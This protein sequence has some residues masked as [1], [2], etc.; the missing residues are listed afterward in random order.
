MVYLP[1]ENQNIIMKKLSLITILLISCFA[2]TNAQQ[3][4]NSLLWK[5]TG[6]SIEHP[7]YLYGTVHITCDATLSP[8]I[9]EALDNTEQLVL[10]LDMDD[11]N[12]QM[13]MMNDIMMKDGKTIKGLLSE[14][15]FEILD[16]FMK[17]EMGMSI[18][19]LNTMKPFLINAMFYPKMIDCPVQSFEEALMKVT[20]AQE[21]EILG[22]ETVKEQLE[23]FDAIPYEDQLIDLMRSVK[24]N[25]AYDKKFFA[26]M[27][28]NYEKED[29]NSLMDIMEDEAFLTSSKHSDKLL[30]GRNRNW[31]SKIESIAKEK[32]TFFGVGAGHLGGKNGVIN[33]L[34]KQGFTVTAVR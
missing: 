4:E 28:E 33:L 16:T 17:R 19:M 3:L 7:S 11:P 8:K 1:I 9:I 34:R 12:L 29:L 18:E 15:D 22:L 24:D 21:E 5:I 27:L 23:V 26:Q 14:E 10:E 25:L 32:A 2:L 20:K 6:D 31:I 13:E 30:D